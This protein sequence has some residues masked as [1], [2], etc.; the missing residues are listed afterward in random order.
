MNKIM[1]RG[2]KH[3]KGLDSLRFFAAYLV[4]MNHA[5]QI[6]MNHGLFNLK[7]YSLFNNGGIAV[8]FFFVLSG[9]LISYLLLKEYEQTE[10]ISVKKFYSRRVLRIW[11]LYF[12]LVM[13]G[14]IFLPYILD[15]LGY[16][17]I[18]PYSFNDVVWYYIF[19]SP[20]MVNIF[21]GHHLIEPL[22]SIGVEELFYILW[23]P[24]FK[25][26]RKYILLFAGII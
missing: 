6:R 25:F 10:T 2:I 26:L 24:L 7:Q 12:L 18:M 15:I 16:S 3:F 23:A 19:F 20:F 8:T 9:F 14:T 21:Y 1:F 17:Y 13:I 11:P 5:E 22:W 4:V